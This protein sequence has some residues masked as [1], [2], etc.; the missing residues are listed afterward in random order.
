MQKHYAIIDIETTGGRAQR[1]R[2]TEI[3]IVLHDGERIIRKWES[4]INP[5][6]YIPHGITELTGI[7]QEMVRDAP[8]FYETAKEIVELTKDAIFVAH[9]VRFDYGFLC[10]EFKRLGYTYTRKQL[11][12][13]RMSRQAFPGL[14]SYSLG[15]LAASLG[16]QLDNRHRA[17]GDAS[18]TAEIFDLILQKQQLREEIQVMINMGIRESKLPPGISLETIHALP[19]ACG[20]YYLHDQLGNVVYVGK[21]LNIRKRVADH[22]A[23]NS[24]KAGKLRN[25]VNEVSFEVT[26]SE[27]VALLLESHEIKRLN[28]PVNK[29]QRARS[30]PYAIYSW[31]NDDGYLCFGMDKVSSK[32]KKSLNLI[33]EYAQLAHARGHIQSIREQFGLC[34]SLCEGTRYKGPCFFFH[35]HQCLGACT[36]IEPPDTYNERALLAMEKMGTLFDFDFYLID[37]GRNSGEKAVVF[38]ENGVYQ[39]FGY[40]DFTDFDGNPT[41]LGDTVKK[42]PGNPETNRIIHRYLHQHPG[43]K[44]IKV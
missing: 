41:V 36:G 40:L 26:G 17:M 6:C 8:K 34:A 14:P 20:V 24:P 7:T 1:D 44:I 22:F 42:F 2:I 10:E 5:E 39:G 27:L 28:P 19:E 32:E 30:Y 16:V 3:A 37:E 15:K 43:L 4:L 9:N 11:C 21:S 12:T 33:A 31:T 38:I 23:D 18:A 25:M 13:L 29:A 35:L